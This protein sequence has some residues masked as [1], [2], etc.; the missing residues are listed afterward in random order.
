MADRRD[1]EIGIMGIV[2]LLYAGA[3][4]V[5]VIKPAQHRVDV[6]GM[7][8]KLLQRVGGLPCRLLL[9]KLQYTLTATFQLSRVLQRG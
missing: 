8:N 4:D 6:V 2:V 9:C 5:V 7:I 3:V 1:V